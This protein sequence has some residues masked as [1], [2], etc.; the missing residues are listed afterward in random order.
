MKT[1]LAVTI[2]MVLLD[3][4]A[5]TIRAQSVDGRTR[6][7]VECSDVQDDAIR[8][9]TRLTTAEDPN[10]AFAIVRI[11]MMP[12]CANSGLVV[13]TLLTLRSS[14]SYL[15]SRLGFFGRAVLTNAVTDVVGGLDQYLEKLFRRQWSHKSNPRNCSK[16]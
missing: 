3:P 9:S 5:G 10:E 1:M 4:A 12:T 16:P 2:V 6:L 13:S 8:R 7:F 14:D 15:Y 11:G